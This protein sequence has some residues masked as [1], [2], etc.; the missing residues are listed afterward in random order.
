M[1]RANARSATK[2]GAVRVQ[3]V[4]QDLNGANRLLESQVK[5]GFGKE[6]VLESLCAEILNKLQRIEGASMSEKGEMSDA[7]AQGPWAPEQKK[8]L[9]GVLVQ[10]RQST[11]AEVSE[12]APIRRANQKCHNVE[13]LLSMKCWAALRDKKY[14]RIAKTSMLGQELAHLGIDCPD[15]PTLYR[16]VAI[17]NYCDGSYDQTEPEIHKDMDKV[18][19][20][21][22]G[23]KRNPNMPFRVEYPPSASQF[24]PELH[25]ILFKGDVPVDVDIPELDAI[26]GNARMRGRKSK[27]EV[28]FLKKLP[29]EKRKRVAEALE[30]TRRRMSMKT[31]PPFKAHDL[32]ELVE[33]VGDFEETEVR[34]IDAVFPTGL[35]RKKTMLDLV[36]SEP[37]DAVGDAE[38]AA[39]PMDSMIV[40]AV[41]APPPPPPAVPAVP[42]EPKGDEPGDHDSVSE[43]EKKLLAAASGKKAHKK[44]SAKMKKPAAA[45]SGIKLDMKAE[46]AV[47]EAVAKD[48]K[49]KISRNAWHSR[50]YKKSKNKA[51]A[52]GHPDDMAKRFASE[53]CAGAMHLFDE[54]RK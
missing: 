40:P 5:C 3:D 21:A 27:S 17:L 28:D 22:K 53:I 32:L 6:E 46:I 13:N 8:L 29:A 33:R 9:S 24:A 30:S 47:L 45:P 7:I 12:K 11:H 4:L 10:G 43:M 48:K 26:N 16:C 39:E 50:L 36:S 15:E 42:A 54:N 14:S 25:E 34:S 31:P 51:T 38:A 2:I 20:Y 23:T 41:T 52:H 49:I 35:R 1:V 19:D 18:Q 44:P 37:P